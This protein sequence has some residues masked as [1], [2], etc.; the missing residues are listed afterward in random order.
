ME[1]CCIFQGC[2]HDQLGEFLHLSL[3][4]L[5]CLLYHRIHGSRAEPGDPPSH[6]LW[7]VIN[8]SLS[9]HFLNFFKIQVCATPLTKQVFRYTWKKILINYISLFDE[10]ILHNKY[11]LKILKMECPHITPFG[12]VF[13]VLNKKE[14]LIQKALYETWS[15]QSN[16]NCFVI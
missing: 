14:M 1:S 12:V 3:C 5:R 4:G 15:L 8:P 10:W 9:E 13:T 6:R 16:R 7:F 2:C 11:I